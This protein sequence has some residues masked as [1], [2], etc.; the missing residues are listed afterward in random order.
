MLLVSAP[1]TCITA[2]SDALQRAWHAQHSTLLLAHRATVR[3]AT[4][5]PIRCHRRW[6]PDSRLQTPAAIEGRSKKG[7]SSDV[8]E[9][10]EGL[11][12]E[13]E[14]KTSSA[15]FPSLVKSLLWNAA[16]GLQRG[17]AG[18]RNCQG[19]G[20]VT[21]PACG[22]SRISSSKL[23]AKQRSA[24]RIESQGKQAGSWRVSNRCTQCSGGVIKCPVCSGTGVR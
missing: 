9:V 5:R 8:P 13:E 6:V 20:T 24:Q 1:Y 23:T 17:S 22:G 19:T 12:G 3:H 14:E 18:C 21:C 11:E 10:A 7:A 16:S 15:Y 2:P 4:V